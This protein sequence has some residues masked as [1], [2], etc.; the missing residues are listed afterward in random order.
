MVI[1][2]LVLEGMLFIIYINNFCGMLNNKL[3]NL[4]KIINNDFT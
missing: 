1:K 2:S 3:N 4:I